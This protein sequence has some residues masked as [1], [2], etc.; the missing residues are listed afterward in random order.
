MDAYATAIYNILV[1]VS[2][3]ISPRKLA[4]IWYGDE[5]RSFPP[6]T[7][8]QNNTASGNNTHSQQHVRQRNGL[9]SLL[10][11]FLKI[12]VLHLCPFFWNCY[13]NCYH[14]RK[15]SRAQRSGE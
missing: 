13:W 14:G 1:K 8:R 9:L 10:P 2:D 6:H 11:F 12:L 5:Y 3:E 4:N 15:S 7:I